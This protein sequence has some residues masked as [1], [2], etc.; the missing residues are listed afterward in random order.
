MFPGRNGQLSIFTALRSTKDS[1]FMSSD[2]Y[3]KR[4]KRI[5]KSWANLRRMEAPLVCPLSPSTLCSSQPSK[6][7]TIHQTPQ[8]HL[9]RHHCHYHDDDDDDDDDH[10]KCLA[11][12]DH[13]VLPFNLSLT[14][15]LIIIVTMVLRI[16]WFQWSGLHKSWHL[17][18][19]WADLGSCAHKYVCY[20]FLNRRDKCRK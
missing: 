2:P 20:N 12:C 1:K 4:I 18:P 9:C 10:L 11:G 7:E 16:R 17:L 19:S 14:N 5:E 3:Q 8:C 6:M 13:P 15:Q